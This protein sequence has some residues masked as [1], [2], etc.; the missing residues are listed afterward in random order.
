MPPVVGRD[1]IKENS[2]SWWAGGRDSLVRRVVG[3]EFNN[4][5][6]LIKTKCLLK[7]KRKHCHEGTEEITKRKL[8]YILTCLPLVMSTGRKL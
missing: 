8:L 3:N 1:V 5:G 7:Y 4:A 6:T 2:I